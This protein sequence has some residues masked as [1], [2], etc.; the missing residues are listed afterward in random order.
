M[1]LH[2]NLKA[3]YFDEIR[4]GTKLYE[5]RLY[6]EYWK[7]RLIDRQ[8]DRI[9]IKKGYPKATDTERIL[10]RKWR[11]FVVKTINNP[12][13]GPKPVKVFAIRV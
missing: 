10:V 1:D 8:F 5:Y 2:L 11:G 3:Q 6:T 9:L 4:N 12:A 7:K 13:F